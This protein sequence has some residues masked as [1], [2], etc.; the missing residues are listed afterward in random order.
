MDTPGTDAPVLDS[1]PHG[2]VGE[3][4]HDRQSTELNG[5]DGASKS[6]S[7]S[8]SKSDS[9]SQPAVASEKPTDATLAPNKTDSE[10]SAVKVDGNATD[11]QSPV[12]NGVDAAVKEE[13]K[14]G[15]K[16]DDDAK[17][18][19]DVKSATPVPE[20]AEPTSSKS[21]E[22]GQASVAKNDDDATK[23][24]ASE[25]ATMH[26][27]PDVADDST[28]KLDEEPEDQKVDRQVVEPSTKDDDDVDMA[29]SSPS[30]KPKLPEESTG[31]VDV[32]EDS[33]R[34]SQDEAALPTSEVDLGP[35]GMSQLAIETTEKPS[36][37][38]EASSDVPMAEA[39]ITKVGRERDEDAA[40][41]EPAPKRARTEPKDEQPEDSAAE[42]DVM[43][44]GAETTGL[45]LSA[46]TTLSN[47][48]DEETNKRPIS[49]FQRREMRKIVGRIRKTKA[50]FHFRDSVQKLWPGLWDSYVAKVARPMDL[51]ELDRGLREAT[52]PYNTY[53][54]FRKD[55]GLVFENALNFNGP[56][57]DITA[58]AATVVKGIWD[59]VLSIPFEEPAKP[60]AMAKP[61]PIRE[62]RAIVGA[63]NVARR[64]SA[65]PPARP[66]VDA[67]AAT[68]PT[69]APTQE[70]AAAD[71]RSSTATEGDR[72]KR[73]VRAPKPKDIDYTTKLSRKKLKPELQFA[74][75]VLAEIMAARHHEINQWF[76]DPVDAEG[77][78]IPDYYSV[79]KKP[80]DLNKVSRMLSGGEISSLKE[81]EKTVRLIFDNCYKF[82]G[83]VG[84]GNPVSVLAKK[85]EDLFFAQLRGKEAWLAK[86]AKSTN[87][88]AS[89]SNASDEDEDDEDE[90]V[91]DAAAVVVDSKEIEELQ[92]K[93]DEETKQL[94]SMLLTSNQSMIDIQKN[95]VE[96]VQKTL[97]S[98]AQE[99]Q[100]AR[101]KAK[102]EKPKKSGKSGKAKSGAS[103]GR[104]STGGQVKKSG[105][106]KKV[107][108][109]KS[110]SA[111]Q[112]DQIANG[113]NDLEYPHLDR[114][115]DIIKKDTGQNENN[116]GELELD[117]DQL[118]HDA[119]SKL[120]D[121]CR[122][123]LPGFARDMEP[124]S[125]P[126]A[127]RPLAKPSSKA[128]TAAKPKKNKPMSASEQEQRIA[129]LQ[130]L[131][132]M[133]KNPQEP[134][135]GVTQAPTPGAESSDD[136]DS[137][138]E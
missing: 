18:A 52:G 122:K 129:E 132:Q 7:H 64:P 80:M 73:T 106:S 77:L 79:I 58:T 61:K 110:L 115:I 30:S 133:Y 120:W 130:A 31:A 86:H 83:P 41:D 16:S 74:E 8:E 128:S 23:P 48:A 37:P 103:G 1:K 54:D 13:E 3:G 104:K 21:N 5:V 105:V 107:A 68:K 26:D 87:A 35:T 70:Q 101:A 12:P 65:G 118:S 111:A 134:G 28:S 57:H 78:N 76:M 63:E 94:N 19:S 90:D 39:S 121:L 75:E 40:V 32:A 10:A 50:G 29:D 2:A 51:A 81:F 135:P 47:W 109:K 55:L 27:A 91:E 67:A 92:A 34:P 25:D 38:A 127:S 97:I 53:G 49:A 138:E 108:P 112:K 98:K 4:E 126:E 33:A 62:S 117:I 119:L 100:A 137:E 85:L 45:S 9:P 114:A 116:D 131:S 66:A 24:S 113:I 124:I 15:P 71:R 123:A 93:L 59:E 46:L 89:A 84:Q 88:P 125:A 72:P 99:A 102:S 20:A 82:N 22:S 136:S 11:E 95:I 96:I 43:G 36:S 6:E 14:P 69:A 60:R 56:L 17:P 44:A 42:A